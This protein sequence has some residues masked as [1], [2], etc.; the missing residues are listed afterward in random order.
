MSIAISTDCGRVDVPNAIRL[1]VCLSLIAQDDAAS[2]RTEVRL[3]V[4]WA[5]TSGTGTG[6][7]QRALANTAVQPTWGDHIRGEHSIH[8]SSPVRDGC[9]ETV[10]FSVA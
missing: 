5:A 7:G 10:C 9:P 4:I 1:P 2:H 3:V 8:A 6:L